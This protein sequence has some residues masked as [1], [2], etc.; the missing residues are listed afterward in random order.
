[1]DRQS[2][3]NPRI[4]LEGRAFIF[5]VF[6]ECLSRDQGIAPLGDDDNDNDNDEDDADAR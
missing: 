2:H 5:H 1:M 3:G 4:A 6:D